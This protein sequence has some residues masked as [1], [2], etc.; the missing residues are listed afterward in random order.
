MVKVQFCLYILLNAEVFILKLSFWNSSSPFDG[1]DIWELTLWEW[2][3]WGVAYTSPN[4]EPHAGIGSHIRRARMTS[5]EALDW[6]LWMTSSL[7]L[8]SRNG[9]HEDHRQLLPLSFDLAD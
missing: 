4:L 5:L 8:T 3:F 7:G 6:L 2:V 1:I 9:D